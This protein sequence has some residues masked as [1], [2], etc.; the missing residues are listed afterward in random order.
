MLKLEF[1]IISMFF[2]FIS[3]NVKLW[4]LKLCV[5]GLIIVGKVYSVLVG[6]ISDRCLLV[7]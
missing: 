4:L 5:V 7:W 3:F 6:V 1:G 2:L